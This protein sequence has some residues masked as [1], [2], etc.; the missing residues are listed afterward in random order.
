M[1]LS[2]W[3]H[4][5]ATQRGGGRSCSSETDAY[6]LNASNDAGRCV[7]PGVA[8]WAA[9]RLRQRPDGEP[10]GRVDACGVDVRRVARFGLYVNGVQVASTGRGGAI[11]TVVE[12]VVDRGQQPYGEYFHGLIDEVR[13]YNRALTQAEIQ[14]DMTTPLVASGGAGH[15]AA[16]GADRV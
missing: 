13:V 1:T 7:P 6:F 3:I 12:P 5:T 16:V 15:D 14:T 2:A 9:T 4:P 11:Q 8:R 10:G